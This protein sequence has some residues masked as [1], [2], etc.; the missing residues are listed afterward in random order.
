[1][2]DGKLYCNANGNTANSCG[3][4]IDA[5]VNNQCDSSGGPYGAQCTPGAQCTDNGARSCLDPQR[6]KNNC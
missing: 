6:V 2:P 4:V 1:M 5:C 3:D